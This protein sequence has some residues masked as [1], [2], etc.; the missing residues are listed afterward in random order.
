[1]EKKLSKKVLL[2]NIDVVIASI[3]MCALVAFTFGG[4]IARYLL[5]APFAWI[6]EVQAALI[7]W[8]IFGAAGAAFRTGNHAAIEVFYEFFP[9][10]VK[11]VADIIILIISVLTL[12]FLGWFSIQYMDVFVQSGRTTSILHLSYVMIYCVVPVS[13]IW[14][15]FN[16]VLVNFFGYSEK[17]TIEAITEEEME[18]AKKL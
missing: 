6:E 1:M 18:A 16:F 7:V 5:N 12:I 17:E 15:V 10:A 4:V 11:K 2:L 13:C 8:V 9:N 3:A 14:Q